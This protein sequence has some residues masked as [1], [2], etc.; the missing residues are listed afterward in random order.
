M[1][2]SVWSLE[3]ELMVEHMI[4]WGETDA[5]N[6]LFHMMEKM[7]HDQFTR[8]FFETKGGISFASSIN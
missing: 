5:R 6:W 1:A 8:Y 2:N 7:P 3:D 4:T